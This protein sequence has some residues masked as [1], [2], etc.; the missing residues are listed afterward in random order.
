MSLSLKKPLTVRDFQELIYKAYYERDARRGLFKTWLWLLEEI[1]E[2][3]AALRKSDREAIEEE[4]ADVIAWTVS[5][6]NLLKIDV[7]E[8]LLKKYGIPPMKHFDEE[9]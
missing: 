7:E 2:L 9:E 6:A 3:A 5:I 8:A 1:G 4:I